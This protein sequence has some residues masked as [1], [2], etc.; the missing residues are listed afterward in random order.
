MW[1][2]RAKA[3]AASLG[4]GA[5]S[6]ATF[7]SL[8]LALSEGCSFPEYSFEPEGGGAGRSGEGGGAGAGQGGAAG[9][10]GQ[11]GSEVGGAGG[12]AGSVP[13]PGTLVASGQRNVGRMVAH[14]AT[15]FWVVTGTEA[16]GFR[17]GKVLTCP[18]DGCP[19][20]GPLVL[21]EGQHKPEFI[22]LADDN[23]VRLLGE[24]E[25]KYVYWTN[26]GS[27]EVMR[28]LKTGCGPDG[29]T[30]LA[31]GQA[32]PAGVRPSASL[33]RADGAGGGGGGGGV[34]VVF[35]VNADTGEL[36]SCPF[37]GC[38]G[39][40]PSV[41][42][43]GLGRPRLLVSG[44]TFV[45]WLDEVAKGRLYKFR[46]GSTE[47]PKSQSPELATP[48]RFTLADGELFG[49]DRGTAANGYADGKIV[50]ADPAT[51]DEDVFIDG[52]KNLF[53]VVADDENADGT[54]KV[55]W[56]ADGVLYYCAFGRRCV[57]GAKQLAVGVG[58]GDIAYDG[59]DIFFVAG[60]E[61]RK[62]PRP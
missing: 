20:S 33:P 17:D 47:G 13:A 5:L 55:Y 57:G 62:V 43:T 31:V 23:Y 4:L 44:D 12:G 14:E 16:E 30:P 53:S 27:G 32:S 48:T 22:D 3:R 51:N 25:E 42:A 24:V 35:W 49:V 29:P 37:G 11:A 56:N 36:L 1:Q 7:V 60:D 2:L 41:L 40:A 26:S 45:Y 21:A 34:P 52:Q 6:A 38:D 18:T 59:R 8:W 9:E 19:T 28:C 54:G 58:G 50:W 39:Q 10:G 61:I 46:K 15:L